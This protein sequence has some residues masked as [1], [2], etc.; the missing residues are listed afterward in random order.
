MG[1]SQHMENRAKRKL[2]RNRTEVLIKWQQYC[3]LISNFQLYEAIN[4]LQTLAQFGSGFLLLAILSIQV[5]HLYIYQL[6]KCANL[7]SI[8]L[9]GI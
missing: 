3:T 5:I 8:L 7:L 4:D 1:Q 2:Q 9:V 6:E